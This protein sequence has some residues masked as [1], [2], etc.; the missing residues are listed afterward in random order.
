MPPLRLADPR[1]SLRDARRAHRAANT[2]LYLSG[3]PT[4]GTSDW[5]LGT[6]PGADW[7]NDIY[8][9]LCILEDLHG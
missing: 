2:F 5:L 4:P 8:S 7:S 1:S 3:V 9:P 6:A